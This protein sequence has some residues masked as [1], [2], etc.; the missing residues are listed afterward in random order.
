MK[1]K[2]GKIKPL[3]L[4]FNLLKRM[5]QCPFTVFLVLFAAAGFSAWGTFLNVRPLY[6]YE[7]DQDILIQAG[8]GLVFDNDKADRYRKVFLAMDEREKEYLGESA[9]STR[10]SIFDG[11]T[12]SSTDNGF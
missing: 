6:F 9:S 8:K 1:N 10:D 4:L 3:A 5:A 12:A 2:S 11:S 7:D